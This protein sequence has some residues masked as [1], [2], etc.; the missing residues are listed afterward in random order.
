MLPP[1]ER[2]SNPSTDACPKM[3]A[4]WTCIREAGHDGL[5]APREL[6]T[7]VE[8]RELATAVSLRELGS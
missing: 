3:H 5:C 2:G 8:D 1:R 4:T 7:S 6:A